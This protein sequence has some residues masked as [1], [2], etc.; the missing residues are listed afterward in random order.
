MHESNICKKAWEDILHSW[1]ASKIFDEKRFK[2]SIN[3]GSDRR[4]IPGEK[5][6]SC[7]NWNTSFD[8]IKVIFKLDYSETDLEKWKIVKLKFELLR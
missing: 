3:F 8:R 5:K 2:Q 6:F 1:N 4:L 7:E